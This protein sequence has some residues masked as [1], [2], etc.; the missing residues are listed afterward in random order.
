[1]TC[2]NF[3]AISP[4][5]FEIH[6]AKHRQTLCY[7]L[8]SRAQTQAYRQTHRH[9]SKMERH[10]GKLQGS[11]LFKK[12]C[13]NQNMYVHSQMLGTQHACFETEYAQQIYAIHQQQISY[14]Q[15]EKCNILSQKQGR[16]SPISGPPPVLDPLPIDITKTKS[17]HPP[18]HYKIQY[19]WGLFC[20]HKCCF[21]LVI[22]DYTFDTR[23]LH[24]IR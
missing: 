5:V 8:Q 14:I 23:S 1:M 11:K 2:Q 20:F 13:I 10:T 21:T 18:H 24:F 3:K 4:V 12:M 7:K 15:L 17:P 22:I 6:C 9:I 19:F 16:Q